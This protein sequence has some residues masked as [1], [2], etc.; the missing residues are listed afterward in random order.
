MCSLFV[1]AIPALTFRHWSNNALLHGRRTLVAMT[2]NTA[3]ELS[4]EIH[5]IEG[6]DSFIIVEFNLSCAERSVNSQLLP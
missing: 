3:N 5:V 2:V 6:M 1:A 4:S